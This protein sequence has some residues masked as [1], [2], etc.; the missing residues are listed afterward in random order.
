VDI[1]GS[2]PPLFFNLDKKRIIKT[3]VGALLT[4]ISVAILLAFLSLKVW[5]MQRGKYAIIVE[6]EYLNVFDTSDS[7]VAMENWKLAFTV[8]NAK[9]RSVTYDDPS[10][11]QWL[12]EMVYSDGAQNY[13]T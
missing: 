7:P 11:V 3:G 4:V 12:A 5:H 9:N 6:E 10:K 1:Y 8:Q 13:K 2:P